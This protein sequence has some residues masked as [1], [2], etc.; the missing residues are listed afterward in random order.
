[1]Y[2]VTGYFNYEK[3]GYTNT[4]VY[5]LI[6]IKKN[7]EGFKAEPIFLNGK[8]EEFKKGTLVNLVFDYYQ[9]KLKVIDLDLVD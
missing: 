4:V 1:M 7:G 3:N 2:E 5:I 9:G 6:P 8:R